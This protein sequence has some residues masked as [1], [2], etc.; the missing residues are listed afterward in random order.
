MS[1]EMA[2]S[3]VYVRIK[4]KN[5]KY[6]C[7]NVFAKSK[8]IPDGMSIPRAELVAATLNAA[9]GHV[10]KLSLGDYIKSFY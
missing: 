8:I 6:S 5:G 3:V 10:V 9:T 1:L 7:Q 2:C 4:R